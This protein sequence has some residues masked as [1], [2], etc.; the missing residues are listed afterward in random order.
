MDGFV[1]NTKVWINQFEEQLKNEGGVPIE[2]I[3]ELL[4]NTVQWW[5]KLLFATGGKLELPNK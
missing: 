4:T 2:D 5:K 3:T 1:D